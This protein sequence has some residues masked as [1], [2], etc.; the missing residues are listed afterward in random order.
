MRSSSR[1]IGTAAL[2]AFVAFI[3]MTSVMAEDIQFEDNSSGGTQLVPEGAEQ[4]VPKAKNL[5]TVPQG[6]GEGVYSS[7]DDNTFVKQILAAR[8]NEDLVICIAGCYS[9][10]DRVVYAQPTSRPASAQQVIPQ[11]RQKFGA[12]N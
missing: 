8:P 11:P 10:R 12:A 6:G 5:N 4:Y 2:L 7:R 1:S 3:P 9:G